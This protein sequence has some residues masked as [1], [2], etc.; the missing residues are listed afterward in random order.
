M[1]L[2]NTIIINGEE[3]K[4]EKIPLGRYAELLEALKTLPKE[5]V[6]DVMGM[7]KLTEAQVVGKLPDILLVAFPEFLKILAI[8]TN[9]ELDYIKKRVGLM[10]AVKMITIVFK[11]NDYLTL[12]NV[13]GS[14]FKNYKSARA[15]ATPGTTP[16]PPAENGSTK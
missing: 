14:V 6:G 1:E 4:I 7:D 15:E 9:L 16:T 11:V 8:A 12:K 5:I 13:V 3:I 10:E 2:N